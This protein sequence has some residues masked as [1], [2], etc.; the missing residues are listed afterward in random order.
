MKPDFL[1][2][3]GFVLKQ[4]HSPHRDISALLYSLRIR[5]IEPLLSYASLGPA[6]LA[7]A[8]A[9]GPQLHPAYP[10][11]SSLICGSPLYLTADFKYIIRTGITA[12]QSPFQ[13]WTN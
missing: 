2:I 12:T 4:C 3:C 13:I 8:K 1:Q 6:L 10:S 5:A 9:A 7:A 11:S